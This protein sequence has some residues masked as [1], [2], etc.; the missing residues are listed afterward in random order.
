MEYARKEEAVSAKEHLATKVVGFRSL[1]VDHADY[2]MQ[3]CNDLHS[4]TLFVDRLQKGFK[5]GERLRDLFAKY[6]TVNFCQ[7]R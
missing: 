7:V 4:E 6:G 1:R 2:G 5:D 3:T